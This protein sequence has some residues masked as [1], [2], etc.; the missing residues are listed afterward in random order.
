MVI[1][2]YPQQE[3]FLVRKISRHIPAEMEPDIKNLHTMADVWDV[4][5]K[6]YGVSEELVNESVGSLVNFFFTAAAKTIPDKLKELYLRYKQ[7]KNDLVDV[8][9]LEVLNQ[10]STSN[11]I[12]STRPSWCYEKISWSHY[13]IAKFISHRIRKTALKIKL[14]SSI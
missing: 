9:R 12:F 1:P 13:L 5:N 2:R 14:L 10:D 7:V 3:E 11:G 8:N 6:E 4:L